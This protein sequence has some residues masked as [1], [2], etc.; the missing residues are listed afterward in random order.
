MNKSLYLIL[1]ACVCFFAS[2]SNGDYLA[3][4]TA[5]SNNGINPIT[6]LESDEFTWSGNDPVS[7]DIN[8]AHWIADW[9]YY[10]ID[11]TWANIIT[12][13]KGSQVMYIYLRDVW[14][15]NLYDIGYKVPS[16]YIKWSD[17]VNHEYVTF[18]SNLGN[19]GAVFMTRND[20]AGIAGKFYFTG[21][22][23]SGQ[24]I[25]LTNGHFS[26]EKW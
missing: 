10:T 12:A 5:N 24:V 15:D 1:F 6:P 21:V 26:R 3:N 11:S 14:K 16:R 20:S 13:G 17:S 9:S 25:N 22:S 7:A 18:Y 23:L 8:G 4:P 19:S 2:C